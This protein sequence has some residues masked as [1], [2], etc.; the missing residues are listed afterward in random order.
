MAKNGFKIIDAELHVMEPVDLWER[1]IDP[2]FK[3][4]A[5]RRLSERR[6]DIRTVVEGDV[7]ASMTDYNWPARSNEEEDTLAERYAEEIAANFDPA[8][9]V[10]AMDREG[11]DLAVL[12]P[13][14]G[15]YIT[16][17]NG[18]DPQFAEAACRAYNNWLYDYIQ[19]GDPSRMFGAAALSP[20]DVETAVVEA[21]RCVNELG[22]K[23]VFLRPNMYNNR[24][25]HDP[26]YDP[27]WAEVQGI[28]R[29]GGISRDHRLPYARGWSRPV[30]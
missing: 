20:H 27:L 14:S 13:T 21:R 19:E 6:W 10:R 9:Q 30:S 7:M 29:T 25:W 18:M 12:Y 5:P 23:A 17:R 26:H 24:S 4:R 28:G 15:M 22:F 2:E 16:A 1:Y 3:D 11:L 8:S